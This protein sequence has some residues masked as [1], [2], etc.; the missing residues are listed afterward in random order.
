MIRAVK[1]FI[2]LASVLLLA[3]CKVKLD[4]SKGS[5]FSTQEVFTSAQEAPA[6]E[7]SAQEAVEALAPYEGNLKPFIVRAAASS[8]GGPQVI[9]ELAFDNNPS[10]RWSSVFSDSQWVEAYFDRPVGVKKVDIL[11]ETAR[12]ADFSIQLLNRQTNWVEVGRRTDASGPSDTLSLSR[13]LNALGIRIQCDRRA[14]EWGN[15]IYEVYVSG[16]TK[17]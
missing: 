7:A 16:V 13:P 12:A 4:Q 6:Q 10:S 8:D 17:G 14:T 3:G 1:P 5:G 11:W 15:S 9:A 2:L